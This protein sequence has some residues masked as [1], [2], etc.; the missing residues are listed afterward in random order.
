MKKALKLQGSPKKI[1]TDGLGSYPA[2][3]NELGN[4]DKQEIG[5]C[6]GFGE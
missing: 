5:R 6:S 1:T 2:A 4:A 3:M